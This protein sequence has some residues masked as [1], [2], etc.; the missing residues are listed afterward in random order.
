MIRCWLFGHIDMLQ[1]I[2]DVELINYKLYVSQCV[3]CKKFVVYNI[4]TNEMFDSAIV[5]RK[6]H[7][8]TPTIL[9]D[10]IQKIA[11]TVV[12]KSKLNERKK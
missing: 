10:D 5:K 1:N 3:V 4:P 2:S 7:Y 8:K 9:Y 6:K 12:Q 11:Y